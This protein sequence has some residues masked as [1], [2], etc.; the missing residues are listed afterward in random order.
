MNVPPGDGE[1][2]ATRLKTAGVTD[3]THV[4]VVG[5]DHNYQAAP[6][7]FEERLRERIDLSCL[8]RPY[9]ESAYEAVI[10]WLED[11]TNE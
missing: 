2:I 6:N 5:G 8:E 1:I 10:T 3:V 9:L 7:D 11:H 4:T